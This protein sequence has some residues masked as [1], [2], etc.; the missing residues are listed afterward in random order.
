MALTAQDV[1]DRQ[2]RMV[3]QSTGYD[4]E[5]VDSFLDEVEAQ[6][7]SLQGQLAEARPLAGQDATD[8]RTDGGPVGHAASGPGASLVE[9]PATA[10]ARILELAQ[11]TADDYLAEAQRQAERIRGEAVGMEHRVSEL[12]GYENELR[13]RLRSYLHAELEQLKAVLGDD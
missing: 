8:P 5:E 11:R 1:H 4:I 6:L 3:R 9:A 2:F 13:G 12:R 10:A 7:R